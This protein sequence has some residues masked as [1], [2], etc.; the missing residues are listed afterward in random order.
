[1]A[2]DYYATGIYLN[3]TSNYRPKQ[4][5]EGEVIVES[6]VLLNYDIL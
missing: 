4:E 2:G 6:E 1:M 5:R 3:Q